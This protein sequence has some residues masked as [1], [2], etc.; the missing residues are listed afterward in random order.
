MKRKIVAGI[1]SAIMAV[2]M[3]V[4]VFADEYIDTEDIIA[5]DEEDIEQDNLEIELSEEVVDSSEESIVDELVIDE[6]IEEAILSETEAVLS[7]ES[8]IEDED[9]STEA[10]NENEYNQAEVLAE[11]GELGEECFREVTLGSGGGSL[12]FEVAGDIDDMDGD[13]ACDGRVYTP[14]NTPHPFFY[15]D[16]SYGKLADK[17]S[18]EKYK[19]SRLYLRWNSSFESE[20][21]GYSI[22]IFDSTGDRVANRNEI[23]YNTHRVMFFT[24]NWDTRNLPAGEYRAIIVPYVSYNGMMFSA[25]GYKAELNIVIEPDATEVKVKVRPES[26]GKWVKAN[27]KYSWKKS[28]GKYAKN[29]WVSVKG[30]YYYIGNDKVRVTGWNKI[31]DNWYY[32]NKKG[33]MK[34]GFITLK[35]KT[36][37]L[38]PNGCRLTGWQNIKGEKYYF[39]KKGVMKTGWNSLDNKWYYFYDDGHMAA[40]E[41]V[42]NFHVN[43]KGVRDQEKR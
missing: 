35:G 43:E 28:S 16:S 3:I 24:F 2:S 26:K 27:N 40:E 7:D 15:T 5:I 25:S 31:N 37:Y 17:V 12:D 33:V 18:L 21:E 10:V 22:D 13:V 14:Y 34:K 41:W 39:S 20:K 11:D 38:N 36:Y 29:R 30:K 8:S 9:I 23:W 4:P 1:I 32:F 42:G 6:N 19:C